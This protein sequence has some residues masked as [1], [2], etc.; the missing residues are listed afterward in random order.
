MNQKDVEKKFIAETK[1]AL[2]GKNSRVVLAKIRELK[3]TGKV[4][5]LAY[6]LDLLKS[7][8]KEEIKNEIFNL[9]SDLRH[10]QGVPVIVDYIKQLKGS[11]I[12]SQLIS[13]CWQSRLDYSDH[14]VTFADCFISGTYQDAIESFTVIEEMLWRSDDTKIENCR[15]YLLSRQS[16]INNEKKPLFKELIKILLTNN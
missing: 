4:S 15:L 14:L 9:V 12:L 1:A 6:I 8:Q 7:D 3:V 16:E 5:I 13:A 2:S 10:Q 11:A